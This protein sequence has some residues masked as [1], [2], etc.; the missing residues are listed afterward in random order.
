MAGADGADLN[1]GCAD[2]VWS[3]NQFGTVNQSCV[4]ANGG[5]GKVIGPGPGALSRAASPK[6]SSGFHVGRPLG[7]GLDAIV[8]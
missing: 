1:P 6:T 8:G 5:M 7:Q 2:N 4:K 3:A